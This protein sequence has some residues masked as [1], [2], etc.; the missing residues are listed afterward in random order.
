[1]ALKVDDF[2]LWLGLQLK[3]TDDPDVASLSQQDSSEDVGGEQIQT[4]ERL[5]AAL[6]G[7]PRLFSQAGD[8]YFHRFM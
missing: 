1:M 5:F 6:E 3:Y 7:R 2:I 8:Q 4:V